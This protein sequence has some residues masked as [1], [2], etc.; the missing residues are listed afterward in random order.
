MALPRPIGKPAPGAI[1]LLLAVALAALLI[2]PLTGRARADK[3]PRQVILDTMLV[4]TSF[5]ISGSN[6]IERNAGK[7]F[8]PTGLVPYGGAISASPPPDPMGIG[9]YPQTFERLGSVHGVHTTVVSFD[10][11]GG[12]A[13]PSRLWNAILQGVCGPKLKGMVPMQNN[14][15]INPGETKSVTATCPDGKFLVGGAYQRTDFTGQGGDFATASWGVGNN[16][17]MAT[18][19]AFGA[20]GGELNATA[21]CAP[22]KPNYEAESNA[23]TIPPH[24]TA[25]ATSPACP[26]RKQLIFGGFGTDPSGSVLFGNSTFNSDRTYSASGYNLSSSPATITAEGYCLKF[27]QPLRRGRHRHHH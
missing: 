8:C 23:V 9:V 21:F 14:V 22:G 12:P 10:P 24:G 1:A 19:H 26:G 15:F 13:L 25:T 17:W 20:F 5:S 7:V 2:G 18:G 3:H 27:V 6:T 11:T 16:A 4:S